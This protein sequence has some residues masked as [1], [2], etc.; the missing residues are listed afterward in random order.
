MNDASYIRRLSEEASFREEWTS[1]AR[2][3]G[4][5]DQALRAM[6]PPFPDLRDGPEEYFRKNDEQVRHRIRN[7]Y[8]GVEDDLLRLKLISLDR[9]AEQNRLDEMLRCLRE[10]QSRERIARAK[11]DYL[12]LGWMAAAAISSMCVLLGGIFG[13]LIG[14]IAGA[15]AGFFLGIGSLNFLKIGARSNLKEARKALVHSQEGAEKVGRDSKRFP[16]KKQ[17]RAYAIQNLPDNER[18]FSVDR[19]TQFDLAGGFAARRDDTAFIPIIKWPAPTHSFC[20]NVWKYWGAIFARCYANVLIHI[21][22]AP[23]IADNSQHR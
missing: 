21:M 3:A 20:I 13:G 8:F 9:S 10:D 4:V 22:H 6:E 7:L 18:Q 23:Y 19:L 14:A 5:Y 16:L 11:L 1:V 17:R 12:P 15:S 2:Q